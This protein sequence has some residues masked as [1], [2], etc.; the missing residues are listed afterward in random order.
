MI[1]INTGITVLI[2]C[3]Q[4]DARQ[5]CDKLF[6]EDKYPGD[7]DV[8]TAVTT[9]SQELID[10]YPASDPRWAESVPAG[11]FVILELLKMIIIH[12]FL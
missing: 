12:S 1:E 7:I 5:L 3:E 4:E 8:D 9:L 11:E 10:D 6:P 2:V